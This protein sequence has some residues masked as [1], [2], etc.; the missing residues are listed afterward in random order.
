[1]RLAFGK[2]WHKVSCSHGEEIL[3]T[4][5]FT[6]VI[7]AV[8]DDA[9]TLEERDAW[10][11]TKE[12]LE[13]QNKAQYLGLELEVDDCQIESIFS[14]YKQ[15]QDRLYQIIL[16]FLRQTEPRP[17]VSAVVEALKS[18]PVG[19]PRIAR[20]IEEKYIK[21]PILT[22][23]LPS[24]SGMTRRPIATSREQAK[25]ESRYALRG[26]RLL[27]QFPN[28]SVIKDVNLVLLYD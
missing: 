1:M 8:D 18:P 28:V 6:T 21:K 2:G 4:S 15:P 14:T 22:R 13:A 16:A 26:K 10:K 19:L 20:K 12:V 27:E 11:L 25:M 23:S 3:K 7:P 9:L 17:T 24:T 5:F